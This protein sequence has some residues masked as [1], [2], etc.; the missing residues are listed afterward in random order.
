MELSVCHYSYHRTWEAQNWDCG[1]LAG[2]VRDLG[3][4]AIDFHAR[5]LGSADEAPAWIA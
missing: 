1:R 4:G 2:T 3:V 5:L